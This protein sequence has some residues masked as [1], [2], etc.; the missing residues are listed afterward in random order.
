MHTNAGFVEAVIQINT[1][2]K[3]IITYIFQA[4]SCVW[5]CAVFFVIKY[6]FV[7]N[8]VKTNG[9]ITVS[10]N[11]FLADATPASFIHPHKHP[12]T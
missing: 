6:K 1:L 4:V 10:I 11:M 3:F 7:C 2:I 5:W 12:P 8:N 9:R